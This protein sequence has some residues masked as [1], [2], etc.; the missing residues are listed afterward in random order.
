MKNQYRV[1]VE[2]GFEKTWIKILI[3]KRVGEIYREVNWTKE[4]GHQLSFYNGHW[5]SISAER[6]Y[7]VCCFRAYPHQKTTFLWS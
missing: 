2:R 5:V 1:G 3:K 6:R 4:I 7:T